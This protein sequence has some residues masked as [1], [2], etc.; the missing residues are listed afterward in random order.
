M[1]LLTT[2]YQNKISSVLSCFD[3]VIITGTIPQLCYSQG[4]TSYLY[5]H[6][7]RIFDYPKFA[8]PFRNEILK[9]I[10]GGI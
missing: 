5:A 3:Q 6:N 10:Y 2:K 4:I 7:I 9:K 1:K 8:E